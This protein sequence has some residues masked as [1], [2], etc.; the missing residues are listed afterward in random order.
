MFVIFINTCILLNTIALG[1]DGYSNK[2]ITNS[3]LRAFNAYF[4]LLF[5]VEMVLKIYGLGIKTYTRDEFNIFDGLIVIV[6]ITDLILRHITESVAE[7]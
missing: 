2:N 7:K 1:L 5:A 4:T 3:F 6:S